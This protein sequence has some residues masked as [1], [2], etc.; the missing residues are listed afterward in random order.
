[1]SVLRLPLDDDELPQPVANNA[2]INPATINHAALA[3]RPAVRPLIW[4]SP[5][6][7]SDP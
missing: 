1:M 5:F 4:G 2:T 7:F 3:G 6:L